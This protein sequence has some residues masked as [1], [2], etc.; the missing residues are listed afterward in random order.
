MTMILHVLFAIG[1]PLVVQL[2]VSA[3]S[4]QVH[5]WLGEFGLIQAS[6]LRCPMWVRNLTGL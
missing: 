5:H 4:I 1:P 3:M 2:I 6:C